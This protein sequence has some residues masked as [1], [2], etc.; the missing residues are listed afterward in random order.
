MK[1]SELIKLIESKTGKKII[2]K[3]NKETLDFK[4]FLNY[5]KKFKGFNLLYSYNGESRGDG[6]EFND[7][8]N[9]IK[10]DKDKGYKFYVW[11]FNMNYRKDKDLV[12]KVEKDLDKIKINGYSMKLR[13]LYKVLKSFSKEELET[14][15]LIRIDFESDLKKGV[16]DLITRGGNLD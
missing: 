4:S 15:K 1:V 10:R 9:F 11:N 12:S 6:Y 7:I 2:L 3:E 16:N 5:F 8:L 14:I 13:E